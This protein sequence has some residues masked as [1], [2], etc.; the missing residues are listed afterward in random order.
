M[1]ARTRPLS[2]ADGPL[3]RFALKLRQLRDRAPAGR[4][5][6]VTKV[7]AESGKIVSRAAIYSALSGKT[8]PSRETLAVM[9]RAWA[10]AGDAELQVW[11]ERRS[12]CE[13]DISIANRRSVRPMD[14]AGATYD[15]AG[16]GGMAGQA[17][18]GSELRRWRNKAGL[19]LGETAKRINY[20]KSYLSKIENDVKRPNATV[21][22][23]CDRVLG[24]GGEL[25]EL[26]RN[27]SS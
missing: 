20:S 18:F 27:A 11:T 7:V 22:R 14:P 12:K 4:T 19:T 1:P 2:T 9:V 15:S 26:A 24:T 25:W 16:Q 5:T 3:A 8:L 17:S 6:S 23:L 13:I 10:S 21:A